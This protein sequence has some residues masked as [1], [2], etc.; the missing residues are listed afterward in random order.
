MSILQTSRL[1]Q[2]AAVRISA[3]MT[4]QDHLHSSQQ[5]VLSRF[6][7]LPELLTPVRRHVS[8]SDFAA[9]CLVCRSLY[10]CANPLLY[11]HISLE[12]SRGID[13]STKAFSILQAALAGHAE[14]G[15]FVRSIH[16]RS[17]DHKLH[18]GETRT[19]ISALSETI[20]QCPKLRQLSI[21]DRFPLPDRAFT[22]M[23]SALKHA[24]SLSHLTFEVEDSW[25]CQDVGERSINE[26]TLVHALGCP[27]LQSLALTVHEGPDSPLR[28]P[29]LPTSHT[30]TRLALPNAHLGTKTL[31]NIIA[32]VPHVQH[33]DISLLRLADLS[34]GPVGP[35]LDLAEL[36]A[37]LAPAF[38]TVESL[39]LAVLYESSAP[40]HA[41]EGGGEGSSWGP[42]GVFP[43][44]QPCKRLKSLEIAP[45]LLWG[46]EERELARVRLPDALEELL[47]RSDFGEWYLSPWFEFPFFCRKAG[48]YLQSLRHARLKH[49]ALTC[50]DDEVG[51]Y[52]DDLDSVTHVCNGL[53][54]RFSMNMVES[55][56]WGVD[57]LSDEDYSPSLFD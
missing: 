2:S 18:Q 52:K 37:A 13:R 40:F 6:W 45:E 4:S 39:R 14:L 46:W 27:S 49:F 56:S 7:L 24:N 47:L 32:A 16:T 10:Y 50:F 35:R 25:P 57:R 54:V 31:R 28:T 41:Y 9:L 51:A 22:E 15:N 3:T 48:E 23:H 55:K 11:E 19:H 17:R 1:L 38:A 34:R 53:G 26:T 20:K 8:Q 44:L 36:G 29:A 12:H 43:S 30:I 33:L 21:S 5:Q 42:F